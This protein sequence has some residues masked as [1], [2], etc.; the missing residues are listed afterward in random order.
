ML[1][2]LVESGTQSQCCP[3]VLRRERPVEEGRT[4]K[5]L[6]KLDH[7]FERRVDREVEADGLEHKALDGEHLESVGFQHLRARANTES[8]SQ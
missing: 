5:P 1:C 6:S 2:W 8:Q 3:R 4:A 7:V